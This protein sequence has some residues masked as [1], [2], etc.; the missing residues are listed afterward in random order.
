[1]FYWIIS[2]AA[3]LAAC[4]SRRSR[5]WQFQDKLK[6]L[7]TPGY[8]PPPP[9]VRGWRWQCRLSRLFT[10]VIV[11]KVKVLGAENLKALPD[12]ASYQITPNH[13]HFA[14]I[15]VVPPV[16]ND[17][18]VRYMADPGVMGGFFGLFGWLV[19]KMGAYAASRKAGFQVVLAG[20]PHVIFPEGWTYLDG[21][22]GR[23]RTGAV[24]IC[25]AVARETKRESF[26]VPM[27]IKY[28]RY[29]GAWIKRLPIRWQYV[30]L[31]CGFLSFRRGAIVQIGKP[32]S[33]SVLPSADK[34]AAEMLRQEILKLKAD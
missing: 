20:E 23:C 32:L 8:V 10:W 33:S 16:L 2:L 26:L 30:L 15:F 19:G 21:Q 28:G 3:L 9:T 25:K 11:G 24:N 12:G 7:R 17:R 13:S 18:S 5:W 29:P 14:D 34:D 31:L 6:E 27:Y 22:M 4:Y 1:M